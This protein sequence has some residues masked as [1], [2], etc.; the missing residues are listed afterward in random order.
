MKDEIRKDI[1][2]YRDFLKR[3]H[4]SAPENFNMFQMVQ[5]VYPDR[6]MDMQSV[7]NIWKDFLESTPREGVLNF[8]THVP[9]CFER[10]HFCC[11]SGFKLKKDRDLKEYVRILKR[12]YRFFKKTFEGE[13]F[14]N[15]YIGGGTPSILSN[16]LIKDLLSEIFRCFNFKKDGEKT[17]E[18]NPV[19]SSYEK[20][21]TVKSFGFNRVSFGVES[22]NPKVLKLNNRGYQTEEMVSGG[23]KDARKLGFDFINIDLI[24]G[25]YDE[26]GDSIIRGFKKAIKLQPFSVSFYPLQP[27]NEYLKNTFK[28][29]A[30]EYFKYRR[31][32]LKAVTSDLCGIAESAGYL[33]PDRFRIKLNMNDSGS[34]VFIKKNHPQEQKNAYI[35]N[36]RDEI[37]SVLGIG[38]K[39]LSR[40]YKRAAYKMDEVLDVNPE[41]YYFTGDTYDKKKEMLDYILS[42]LSYQKFISK[43]NFYD[44]FG[45]E[46]TKEF[47]EVIKKLKE[48][49]IASVDGDEIKFNTGHPKECLL[50]SLLF[51]NRNDIK[52]AIKRRKRQEGFAN[53][54]LVS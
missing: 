26:D 4:L 12:Y 14:T 49:G 51:F 13:E 48:S 11:Y 36:S 8:Y 41:E 32:I 3:C 16:E 17:F 19:S 39:S 23:I 35:F 25:L 24:G 2:L 30:D 31:K 27:V 44:N 5:A 50:Y 21:K 1:V 9:Y 33:P 29:N 53:H 52:K 45:E 10:C 18:L 38:F 46:I 6:K 40:V 22:F 20:L 54:G 28:I 34:I 43:S 15:L 7:L 47:G 42:N 37:G